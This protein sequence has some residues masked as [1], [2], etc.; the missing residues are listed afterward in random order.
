ML[1]GLVPWDPDT[2]RR[3]VRDLKA[4]R[5]GSHKPDSSASDEGS[6]DEAERVSVLDCE[7]FSRTEYTQHDFFKGCAGQAGGQAG[8]EVRRAGGR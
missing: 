8:G 2:L 4:E 7:D 5:A 1:Q 3:A 6:D